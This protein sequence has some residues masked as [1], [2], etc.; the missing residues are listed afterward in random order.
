MMDHLTPL[1]DK[2][3]DLEYKVTSVE[4]GQVFT[5]SHEGYGVLAEEYQEVV[6]A[7][8]C[9]RDYMQDLL[10]SIRRHDRDCIRQDA[11]RIYN[12]AKDAAC[13]CVQVAAMAHKMTVTMKYISKE[14]NEDV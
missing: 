14:E 5:N 7:I 8:E 10:H 11:I 4:H 13:E 12:R 2:A 9:C 3:V 1:V 6:D